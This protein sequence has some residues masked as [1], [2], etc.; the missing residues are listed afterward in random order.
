MTCQST[1]DLILQDIFAFG[2]NQ[3]M[4]TEMDMPQ[5]F[6]VKFGKTSEKAVKE[7]R[8]RSAEQLFA[9]PEPVAFAVEGSDLGTAGDPFEPAARCINDTRKIW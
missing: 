6:E 8:E 9:D 2:E 7:W 1:Q 4:T 5:S 3:M